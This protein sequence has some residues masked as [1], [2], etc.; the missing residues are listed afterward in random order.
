LAS[1]RSASFP[2]PIRAEDRR[3]PR[4]LEPENLTNRAIRAIKAAVPEIA[5]MTDVALDPYNAHG[6]DGLVATG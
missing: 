5:V 3:L 2:T 4:G 6:H 1:R